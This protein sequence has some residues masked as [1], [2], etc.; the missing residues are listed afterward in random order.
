M[1]HDAFGIFW[2]DPI[3]ERASKQ[4]S[5]PRAL[6]PIPE[7]DWELPEG[8]NAYPDLA[9]QGAISIDVETKDL[10]LREKG[11]GFVRGDAYIVGVAVGTQAG[12]RQYY[13]VAH[14]IGPNLP[15]R[16][17][18]GWLNDQLRDNHQPKV[19]ARLLY[20]LEALHYAGVRNIPGPFY[21]VQIADP[22]LDETHL[23]Y[24]LEAISYR[25]L[26]E[27]KKQSVMLDW[28]KKAFGDETN[29][30][31]NIYR[32]PASIVGPYAISDIDLP[33]R[34]FFESQKPDLELEGLWDLFIMESKLIPMLLAMRL[35]GVPV[36]TEHAEK[37][38]SKLNEAGKNALNQI[39]HLSGVM[40][41]IW[42]ADSIARVFDS[43][44][45]KYPRTPIRT[46]KKTNKQT[47]G[48]PSF[49]KEW[50]AS[51]HH[52]VAKLIVEAR[53]MEKLE[54]TFVQGYILDGHVKGRI[55]SQFHQLKGDE[56]GTISGRF[57]S[58]LPNLQNIPVRTDEGQLIRSAFIADQDQKW[59]KYD[60]SQLEYRIIAHYASATN[61]TG[62]ESVI[63]AYRTD[64]NTDYHQAVAELTGLPRK[65]AKN[66]NFGL[67][68]GQGIPLL[69]A[70]LGVD[71]EEGERIMKTYHE[72]SPFMRELM[73]L[74]SNRANVNGFIRTLL[75][76]KRRFNVW[77]RTRRGEDNEYISESHKGQFAYALSDEQLK[78]CRWTDDEINDHDLRG[79]HNDKYIRA[80][81][82]NGWRRA[83]LHKTLN[84]LAQGTNADIMK[85]AMVDTWEAGCWDVLGAPYLTVHDELDGAI[86]TGNERHEE[87]LR[88]VKH[89]METVV[90]L[91]VPLRADGGRGPNWGSIA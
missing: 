44:G 46:N 42:S 38:K 17:V 7:S 22:L 68:Y 62:I 20:D 10:F 32:A 60:W 85:K 11:P 29:I 49:R 64:P 26:G 55:Y 4:D 8:P 15:A 75:G 72:R 6:P 74:T 48:A 33:L 66:L 34:V 80:L 47:G 45:E 21:D 9:G 5:G 65:S 91:R 84:A 57:S 31:K 14:E 23:Q 43:I 50:L 25:R 79:S 67:A 28:L 18:F 58:S 56:G 90:T 81:K 51:H 35:R 89:I 39:K 82:S 77:E 13:P 52:P 24:S 36:D 71:R 2:E 59:W 41:D 37:L 40:P 63:E 53:N 86:E 16:H 19:G 1:R 87:A 12:F 78:R 88:E 30:K 76:R 69:C 73:E 54:T 3:R 83:F 70:N 61:C 27:G